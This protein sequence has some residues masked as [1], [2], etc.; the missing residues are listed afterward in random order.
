M[1][2]RPSGQLIPGNTVM[3]I[4]LVR[5]SFSI[6]FPVPNKLSFLIESQTISRLL[7]A[8]FTVGEEGLS[9]YPFSP[10]FP[11]LR[12]IVIAGGFVSDDDVV[13]LYCARFSLVS[14][15]H[16]R[17]DVEVACMY[18]WTVFIDHHH[19]K[20]PCDT[21]DGLPFEPLKPPLK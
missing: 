6:F 11:T 17:V 16:L 21:A 18:V 1:V 2:K 20:Q 15:K 19:S 12:C 9:F 8:P 10:L 5:L 7:S 13:V 4:S 3:A 14:S